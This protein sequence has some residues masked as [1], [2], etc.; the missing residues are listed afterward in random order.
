MTERG[1]K[2]NPDRESIPRTKDIVTPGETLNSTYFSFHGAY[3]E[4]KYLADLRF[5]SVDL[6]LKRIWREREHP[7]ADDG[8]GPQFN[9]HVPMEVLI[10]RVNQLLNINDQGGRIDARKVYKNWHISWELLK[11]KKVVKEYK[12]VHGKEVPVYGL[13][14]KII[15]SHR[16]TKGNPPPEHG[17]LN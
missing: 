16:Q 2:L 11:V 15:T 6:L 4:A 3:P 14:T 1:R 7:A 8:L 13:V 5:R 10:K 9:G 12:I 17:E